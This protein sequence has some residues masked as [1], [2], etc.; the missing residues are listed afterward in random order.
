MVV[1]GLALFGARLVELVTRGDTDGDDPAGSLA[2]LAEHGKAYVVT[3]ILLVVLAA[4]LVVAAVAVRA[5]LRADRASLWIDAAAVAGYLG[6]GALGLAG[7]MRVA[8]PGPLAYI[9]SLDA[10][11]GESAYL[12]VQVAG[13][14]TLFADGVLAL[15]IWLLGLGVAAWRRR[16]VPRALLVPALFGLDFVF[17]LAGPLVEVPDGAFAV[18]LFSLMIGVPLALVAIGAGFGLRMP[19]RPAGRR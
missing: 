9:S 13:T 5:A 18:H 1:A 4:S 3:G 16:S 17:A 2:Y 10:R 15:S 7:V 12:V 19:R 8:T 14:Q 11:W 6:A